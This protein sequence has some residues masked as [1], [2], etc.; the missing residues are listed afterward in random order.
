MKRFSVYLLGV[1]LGVCAASDAF[2]A[3][4]PPSDLHLVGDHWTAWNPP[5]PPEG[6]QVYTIVRGD[7]LWDLANRFLGNPYLWPQ[8]WELNQYILDA[9]WIY[10]GDPLVIGPAATGSD[11]GPT[12]EEITADS[13][14]GEYQPPGE[15]EDTTPVEGVQTSAA[16]ASPPQALG[17]ESDIYCTGYIGEDEETFP[18]QVVGSE[19]E[20]LT[21][22]TSGRAKEPEEVRAPV[23]SSYGL[24]SG[25][26]AKYGMAAGDIVYLDGGR[27]KGLTPGALFTAVL[28]S[29]R[30]RHPLFGDVLGRFY[31][32]LGRIR[33]LSVQEDTAI[34]EVVQSCDPIPVGTTLKPFEEEPVPLGR[35][36][37]LRPVN[38][39]AT[40]QELEGA[41]SIVFAKDGIVT[42]G[43]DHVVF[44]DRGEEED[45]T[46]GDVFTIYR[47][48]RPGMPPLVIGEL[49]VLSVQRRTALTKIIEARGPIFLGD[50]LQAKR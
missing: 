24:S 35:R 27:A 32:Y 33:V 26:T 44:I 20:N 43:Q 48:N 10:P 21:P 5:V 29:N 25:D 39:P 34:A 49:A 38:F 7:T 31:S 46:P 14:A 41:P 17:S 15:G 11:S 2:A 13:G 22:H 9:H 12:G 50:R 42:L 4:R 18:I 16:A 6:V 36:A 3:D 23:V 19:F 8:I 47:L 40:P 1:A 28:P 30:I 37:G 45:V